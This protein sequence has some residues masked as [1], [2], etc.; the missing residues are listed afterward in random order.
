VL[1]R[2]FRVFRVLI[3]HRMRTLKYLL[4][5]EFLQI[6]RTKVMLALI[7]MMPAI[8][9][10]IMPWATTF[11]QK[12]ILLNIVDNDHSSASRLLTEKII[13][14]A[15]FQLTGAPDNISEAVYEMD[16]NR[17]DVILEIPRGFENDFVREKNLDLM[18]TINAVNGQ[19]AGLGMSYLTRIVNDYVQDM[20][21]VQ[22]KKMPQITLKPYYRY[23]TQL[24]YFPFMVPGIL[25]ILLTV[26]TGILSALNIVREKEQGTIE[27]INVTPVP[28]LVFILGKII[29]FWIIG[30]V[31]LS[32]GIFIA[33]LV[34]GV[35][36]T[37]SLLALYLFG[38]L[39]IMVFTGFGIIISN[40]ASTQQQAMFIMFFFL[41]NFVML[42]GLFTPIS[43][44]P[45]WAQH[46]TA[47]NP[48]RY[49]VEV[50]RTV[51]LKGS[52]IQDILPQIGSICIFI[53]V[54]NTWAVIS[55]RK[56]NG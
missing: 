7:I 15:Y 51:Y 6:I 26:V 33:W 39:F 38:L 14:S 2:I 46:I 32:I 40:Y 24:S 3:L 47:I 1:F 34:Y 52:G 10:L 20:V 23:N 28:K 5:K 35:F 54:V 27:Q 12:N 41:M 53:V 11:E 36:P 31:I 25:V 49:F 42:S 8:Q 29:P 9:L 45:N 55:Y 56:T 19:K 44:M 21:P 48:L 50:I 16:K 18:I 37:G 4:Q 30:L 13:S 17:A 43:S 22:A